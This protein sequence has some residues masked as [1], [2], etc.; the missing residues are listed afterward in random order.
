MAAGFRDLLAWLFGWRVTRTF[1]PAGCPLDVTAADV[2]STG[3]AATAVEHTGCAAAA[4]SLPGE[5]VGLADSAGDAAGDISGN[6]V[7]VGACD[8]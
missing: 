6:N 8:G 5:A 3:A 7:L 2:L 1:V 4:V